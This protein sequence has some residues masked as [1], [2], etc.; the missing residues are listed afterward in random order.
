MVKN[1]T[2]LKIMIIKQSSKLIN[3]HRL[4]IQ[5]ITPN[6]FVNDFVKNILMKIYFIQFKILIF[7]K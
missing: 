3:K 6:D 5:I 1:K 7:I 4:K 2:I